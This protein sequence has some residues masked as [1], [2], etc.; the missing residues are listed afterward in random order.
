M[1]LQGILNLWGELIAHG[2]CLDNFAHA[3]ILVDL[4]LQS[5]ILELQLED[6]EQFGLFWLRLLAFSIQIYLP[7]LWLLHLH[8]SSKDATSL[9]ILVLCM[10]LLLMR[11]DVFALLLVRVLVLVDGL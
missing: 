11:V 1:S 3:L 10:I 8:F 6:I 2:N 5:L 4:Y 9:P 7:V